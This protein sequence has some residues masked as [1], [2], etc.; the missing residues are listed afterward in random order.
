MKTTM[1]LI[2]LGISTGCATAKYGWMPAAEKTEEQARRELAACE[3]ESIMV[4]NDKFG[5]L[6]EKYINRCMYAQG[7]KIVQID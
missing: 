7:H 4:Q 6:R 2:L 1:L 5:S 3:K